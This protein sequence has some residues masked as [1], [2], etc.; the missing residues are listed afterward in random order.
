M[1]GKRLKRSPLRVDLTKK[2]GLGP[3]EKETDT[4][5]FEMGNP[6]GFE[7]PVAREK[8]YEQTEKPRQ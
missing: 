7:N 6:L 5:R 1:H 2:E 4:V 8:V 3:R